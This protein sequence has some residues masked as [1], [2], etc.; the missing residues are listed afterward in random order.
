M[1]ID[2][3]DA[4]SEATTISDLLPCIEVPHLICCAGF[5][6]MRLGF[7]TGFIGAITECRNASLVC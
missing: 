4:Q 5:I 6:F 3:W 1:A 7:F 2:A